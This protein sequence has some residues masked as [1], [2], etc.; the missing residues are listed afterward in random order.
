MILKKHADKFDEDAIGKFEVIRHNARKMGQLIDELLAFSR[1]S[2]V[3]LSTAT[4]DVGGLIRDVWEE[5]KALNPDRRIT[6]KIAKMPP[7]RGD[8]GLIK[9]ALIN[10]LSNAVKFTGKREEALVE[11]GCDTNNGEIVYYIRDNGVGFDMQYYGKLFGVFQRLHSVGDFDGTGV[12]LAIV[13]RIINRHGGKVW[14]EAKVDEG[15]TFY[16]T[17]PARPE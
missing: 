11:A 14:A 8:R 15:A 17:L 2:R 9:Q 4:L 1:L 13:Q 3:Q 5:L 16:F 7:S 12:G 10:L 6:L